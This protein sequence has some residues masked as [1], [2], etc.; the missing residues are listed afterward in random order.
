MAEESMAQMCFF[1]R[2]LYRNSPFYGLLVAPV[3]HL[4][5]HLRRTIP[6]STAQRLTFSICVGFLSHLCRKSAAEGHAG[7]K[8]QR[9]LG[10]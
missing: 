6:W 4:F 7:A 8:V 2:H 9:K 1:M 10:E 3:K 5:T